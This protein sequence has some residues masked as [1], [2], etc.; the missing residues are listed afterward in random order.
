MILFVAS[1]RN[2]NWFDSSMLVFIMGSVIMIRCGSWF[3]AIDSVNVSGVIIIRTV[4]ICCTIYIIIMYLNSNHLIYHRG[5]GDDDVRDLQVRV[6]LFFIRFINKK[7]FNISDLF[8]HHDDAYGLC[9]R[10][11]KESFKWINFTRP[12][13]ITLTMMVSSFFICQLSEL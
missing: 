13:L 7:L 2:L 10:L 12:I 11:K 8:S 3:V 5:D 6:F 4:V 9:G 1:Q